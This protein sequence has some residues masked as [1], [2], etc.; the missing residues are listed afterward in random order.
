MIEINSIFGER[1]NK[2]LNIEEISISESN[3]IVHNLR[4]RQVLPLGQF[5]YSLSNLQGRNR[6]MVK[7]ELSWRLVR[8][9]QS[10]ALLLPNLDLRELKK[11]S[12]LSLQWLED[13]EL[14]DLY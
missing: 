5:S 7:A 4:K 12:T 11:H 9:F 10:K 13:G 3:L 6:S 2:T 14:N 8:V 1:Y